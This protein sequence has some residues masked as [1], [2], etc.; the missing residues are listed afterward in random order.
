M[1]EQNYES[2]INIGRVF[3]RIL[4][5]WRKLFMIALIVAILL[6]IG[7]FIV[8]RIRISD[9]GYMEKAEENY[10]REF[11]AF[12]ATGETLKHEIENLEETRQERETYNK[13]SILMNINPFREFNASLQLYV[14]TDYKIIPELTYQDI[15]LSNRILRS[16]IT[17]MVNGDMYQY[18]LEHLSQPM[19][20][21]YLK[22][23]LT[24]SADYDNRMVNLS[25]RHVDANACEEILQYALLGVEEKKEGLVAAIGE[26]ELNAINQS[27]YETVNLE[28]DEWQKANRQYMLDLSIKLQEK[29]E[30]FAKWQATPKPMREYTDGRIL[31]GSIKGMIFGF[32]VSVVL[33][34]VFIAFAYIM[35]DKLQD[36]NELKERFGLRVIAQIPKVHKKRVW[37]GLDRLFAHMAGL[38][39]KENDVGALTKVASQSVCAEL[40]VRGSEPCVQ[41]MK[42]DPKIKLVF[43]GNVSKAESEELLSGMSWGEGYS[44]QCVSNVL[45]DPAAIPI[46]TN[47]DYIILVE[48]QEKS[49]YSEIGR[50]LEAL[51]AWKKEVL[52]VIVIGV[53]AIP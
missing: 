18:I 40:M 23:I 35:S 2:E 21:R 9:P 36:A 29:S 13:A 4:R 8:K 26:H 42:N 24:V 51:K 33:V 11:T 45:R 15:D 3:Y 41:G 48:K 28:L 44:V 10:L 25:V 39:F 32:L 7:T 37:V 20:L 27:V 6:G 49:T 1:N 52:G 43:T 53:D 30:E 46:V 47:A 38:M 50:E 5:D 22:E 19:E 12:E 31:K 14:S 17:Y 34:A 16:Y